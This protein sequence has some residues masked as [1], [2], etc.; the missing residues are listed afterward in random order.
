MLRFRQFVMLVE[1]RIE[2]LKKNNSN[3]DYSHDSMYSN[4]HGSR[5]DVNHSEHI[6]DHLA[7][8]AD[9]T[10]KKEYTQWAVGQYKKK[11]I[12]LEDAPRVH[13]A[14]KDFHTHKQR[15]EK[16]D[17]NQYKHV[18]DVEDAVAPH[19]GTV[20]N[21]EQKR[22]VKHD[23]ADLV[24]EADTG[25]QIH[26]LK[27]KE[28]AQHYGAGTR[29]C[30]AGKENNMFDYYHKQGP[31]HV[32][33]AKLDGEHRKF[34]Y[35]EK[36]RQFMNE[37]DHDV[38]PHVT[39]ALLKDHPSLAKEPSFH[40]ILAK[41]APHEA[42]NNV[43]HLDKHNQ[44][45]VLSAL[46]H[47]HNDKRRREGVDNSK[48]FHG[49]ITKLMNRPEVHPAAVAEAHELTH[50]GQGDKDHP[51]KVPAIAEAALRHPKEFGGGFTPASEH[52][53][54]M[55]DAIVHHGTTE[56]TKSVINTHLNKMDQHTKYGLLK[57]RDP[58]V[59]KWAKA[60]MHK[61]DQHGIITQFGSR[62]EHKELLKDPT[63]KSSHV[64][65]I[66][67]RGAKGD[68]EL[69]QAIIS[70]PNAGHAINISA[71]QMHPDTYKHVISH[72]GVTN[73]TLGTLAAQKDIHH[74]D[75][76]RV[77]H[78]PKTDDSTLQ[79]I[80]GD[81][82]GVFR[83]NPA[84]DDHALHAKLID[85]PKF[86]PKTAIA[87]AYSEQSIHN[88]LTSQPQ[89]PDHIKNVER[90]A[91]HPNL[92]GPTHYDK[93]NEHLSKHGNGHTP[94]GFALHAANHTLKTHR[95]LPERNAAID[96]AIAKAKEK[97][98]SA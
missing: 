39:K 1:D 24:H 89:H 37:K 14:L 34:Q 84:K 57:H 70:H 56:Q 67:Q 35:H 17:I 59:Q 28:A 60:T 77:M 97:G 23:G 93:D 5:K 61:P 30:T 71:H 74:E 12:R 72:P 86:G 52:G 26:R 27:T 16:K 98:T 43:P 90:I 65:M 8:H 45:N 49:A 55:L 11:N 4:G 3:I 31:I 94:V 10:P 79:H 13:S 88:T 22:V 78:H 42:L 76:E 73:H 80:A 68:K 62:E 47:E 96:S 9:P 83:T 91:R 51:V 87:I 63:L 46:E 7:A 33:Q 50:Y 2:F 54:Q 29:W 6:I 48:E 92:Q 21:K 19:L 58:E 44:L 81:M 64:G 40:H 75:F 18:S 32:I 41:H 25:V 38:E 82:G 53:R 69:S 20:S 15:L 66:A 36:S 85:H 95:E